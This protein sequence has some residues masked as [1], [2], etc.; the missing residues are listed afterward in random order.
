VPALHMQAI[1]IDAASKGAKERDEF[2]RLWWRME[3]GSLDPSRLVFLRMRWE[4]IPPWLLC[5]PTP[6]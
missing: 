6:P 4:P 5:M 1:P 3:L 2:L